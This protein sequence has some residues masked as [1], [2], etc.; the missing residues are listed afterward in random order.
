MDSELETLARE[1]DR[2]DPLGS[3]RDHFFLPTGP[4]GSETVYLVGNSL[5]LQPKSV[6]T[7]LSAELEKWRRLGVGG[8]FRGDDPWLTIHERVRDPIADLVGAFPHEVVVMNSLTVNLHLM[9]STFF[10][11][12]PT[13]SGILIEA[14][15]FP[16]DRYAVSS[17]L[18]LHGLEPEDHLIELS[19]R[20]G[21]E[22]LRTE[23]IVGV[24]EEQSERIALVVL[25]GLNYYTGQVLDVE[26]ISRAARR[27]EIPV[28][29]DMA[30]AVGNVPLSLHAWGCD[31]AVWCS[32]KYLN[33]GP[34]AVGGCFLHE[35]HARDRSK[36]RLAGWWGH[37]PVSRFEMPRTFRPSDSADGWQVSGPPVLQMAAL[38]ASLEEFE[39]AG[40]T[41]LYE[42][43]LRLNAF[44]R[45]VLA[46]M[47]AP[48]RI[49]TPSDQGSYGCQLSL[50]FERDGREIADALELKGVACDYRE[51]NV[52]RIAAV[53]LYNT[54]LDV[55]KFGAILENV[56]S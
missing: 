8:H 37:E 22:T 53:P 12:S 42:K 7:F 28:G 16:S 49:I 55:V 19:P 50:F 23:D 56:T 9:L 24:V 46:G 32:Y 36:R 52:I 15:A 45:K 51:P 10:R 27:L 31:F 40:L 38:R 1:L 29:F 48:F 33:A 18:R 35:R 17:Q 13:R 41:P 26:A 44:M 34:G 54:F 20:P 21:E 2:S 6:E 14:N 43:A 5:G 39:A 30:H 4:D 25:G 47:D 11:P 3:F